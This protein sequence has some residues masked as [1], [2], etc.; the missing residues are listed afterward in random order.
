[1][2]SCKD[3]PVL[4]SGRTSADAGHAF[5]C[6]GYKYEDG[7]DL[8]YLNWGWGGDNNGYFPL[9]GTAG[10]VKALTPDGTGTGGGAEGAAYDQ[11]QTVVIGIQ[12]DQQGAN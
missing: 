4:Y 3:R 6:D 10:T 8:F 2:Q 5:V 12:P 7:N 11:E 1:M 9:Q